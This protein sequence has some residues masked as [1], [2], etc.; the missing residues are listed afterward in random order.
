MKAAIVSGKGQ[1]PAYGDFAEPVATDGERIVAVS[2]SAISPLARGRAAGT[3]YSASG[4]FPF[5]AGVDGVGRLEDGRRVYFALPR[6][7][8]GALAERV[9]VK[10]ALCV[11]VPDSLDDVR[12]AAL[13][14]P[15]MSSWAA[16]TERARIASGDTVLVNGATGTSGRLA[17][18]I[19]RHLGAAKV[20]AT[21]RN[22]EALR[23]LSALGADVTIALTHDADALEKALR[24]QVAAGIDVVVDYLWGPSAE[25]LLRTVARNGPDGR[26]L[27]FVQVGT[28]SG[29]DVTLPGAVLRSSAIELMG[30]GIGSVSLPG[31]MA[32]VAGVFGAAGPAGLA[33]DTLE[34]PLADIDRAWAAS[35]GDQRVVVKI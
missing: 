8:F 19:A 27:R 18:R 30:S 15:G 14:N 9:P 31:L 34:M 23:A 1:V 7:P 2:A 17:V 16:L 33:I 3:H 21:G 5:V 26:P 11:A 29:A 4:G 12:A 35:S 20:I 22:S 32:A 24:D 25:M 6:A 10:A 13:A 28:A